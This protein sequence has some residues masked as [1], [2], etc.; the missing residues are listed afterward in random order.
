MKELTHLLSHDSF[1]SLSLIVQLLEQKMH[2]AVLINL[3][4]GKIFCDCHLQ[5]SSAVK[6]T[7]LF[8]LKLHDCF[9]LA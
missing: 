1:T 5:T 4:F 6:T 9:G 8:T 3:Y 7:V 2:I